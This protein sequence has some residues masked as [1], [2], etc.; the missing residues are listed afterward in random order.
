VHGDGEQTRCFCHVIDVVDAIVRLMAEP[1][2]RGRVFNLGGEAEVSINDLARRVIA[3]TASASPIEHVSYQ[4]A[5]GQQFEDMARR[6][7]DLSRIREAIG[8]NPKWSL[9]QIV[10]SVIDAHRPGVR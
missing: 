5:Y 4:E 1:A 7:P 10:R 9:E 3:M 6:V 8:F 2:A